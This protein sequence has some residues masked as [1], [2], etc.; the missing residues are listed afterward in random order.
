MPSRLDN[1]YKAKVAGAAFRSPTQTA[2]AGSEWAGKGFDDVDPDGKA[3][4][5]ERKSPLMVP[6]IFKRVDGLGERGGKKMRM[7]DAVGR[8]RWDSS[9]VRIGS[10]GDGIN[11]SRRSVRRGCEPVVLS[12]L[13]PSP[14]LLP[15]LLIPSFHI[16]IHL[17]VRF[18]GPLESE[19]IGGER[20]KGECKHIRLRD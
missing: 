16:L 18:D 1:G 3:P 19:E 10:L 17:G 4:G 7:S 5:L 20:G 6:S 9:A 12:L 11:K 8:N 13:I 2:S 14:N 15:C